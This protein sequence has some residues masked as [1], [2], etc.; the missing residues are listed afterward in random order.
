[1]SPEIY[2][3]KV[4]ELEKEYE[5]KK[6]QLMKQFVDANNPYKI[7]DVVIDHVGAIVVEKITYSLGFN[8]FPCAIYFGIELK[9]DGTPTK[10]LSKR[11][12]WQSN[13]LLS[14]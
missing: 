5:S 3:E 2:K 9:K 4:K 14:K 11:N 12:V 6:L 8:S 1:M 13:V 7:G 10:E